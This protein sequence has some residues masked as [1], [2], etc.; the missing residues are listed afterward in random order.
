MIKA[1]IFDLDNTLIDFLKMKK[2]SCS[3]AIDAMIGAGLKV[4]HD[5][6]IKV[7]LYQYAKNE[8]VELRLR[9]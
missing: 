7:L 1:V 6:A 3:A 4:E 2:Q 5:K 8:N 9:K